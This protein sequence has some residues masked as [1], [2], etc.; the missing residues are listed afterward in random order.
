MSN[1]KEFICLEC[2]CFLEKTTEDIENNTMYC[3]ICDNISLFEEVK[4]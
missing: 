1:N 4:K 2:G 3:P